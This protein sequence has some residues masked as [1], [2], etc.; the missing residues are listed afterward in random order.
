MT[1]GTGGFGGSKDWGIGGG[2]DEFVSVLISGAF[3]YD[4]E[5]ESD[6]SPSK[7]SFNFRSLAFTFLMA[8][9]LCLYSSV[10]P[11]FA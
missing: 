5:S 10:K 7:I 4:D 6:L 11:F 2:T 3:S 9:F 1:I 8:S